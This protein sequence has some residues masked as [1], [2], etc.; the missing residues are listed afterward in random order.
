MTA[1]IA[2]EARP[3]I[4]VIAL[5]R[6]GDVLLTTPLIRSVRRAWPDAQIDALVF[7]DTAGILA[8]NPDLNNVVTMPPR[9]TMAQTF[10]LG[11]RMWRRYDLAISSQSGDRPTGFAI[12]AGRARIAPVEDRFSG[13]IKRALLDRNV[14]VMRGLHR[15]EEMLR[16]ADVLG[17]ARVPDMVTPQ[18]Q[19]V[20]GLPAGDYAVIY[21]APMFRYKQ[22]TK[23]GWRALAEA[24]SAK[25]LAVLAT[26]GPAD[27]ER[28]YLDDIWNGTAVTRLDGRVTWPQLSG[29]LAK[30]RVYVGPDTSVTHLAAASGCPTVALYGPTD[31]RLWA[32]WPAHGL[33]ELWQAT[34][35]IQQRDNVWLV[36]HAFP[37]TPCQLEGCERGLE[38]YSACL[39]ELPV[40][41]VIEAVTRAL[42]AVRV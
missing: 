35:A 37:C 28:R 7:A 19:P 15:V 5:R 11:R 38:S 14:P 16:L 8:G 17:I 23:D 40:A 21:A 34:G 41:Q 26:G 2:L 30:A 29:L 36:Q 1:R 6:L 10:A 22:W 13:R 3:R 42:A 27:S 20:E 25:G 31:P 12:A 4:L 24:L 32:P 39:D 18:P 9:P 33:A